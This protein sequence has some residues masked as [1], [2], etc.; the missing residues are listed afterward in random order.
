M[1]EEYLS[2]D[3]TL[4]EETKENKMR[5]FLLASNEQ[6]VFSIPDYLQCRITLEIMEDPV[7]TDSG[8]TYE[9]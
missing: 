7:M 6:I 5:Q 1:I 8:Q 9:R 3:T 4:D 2:K